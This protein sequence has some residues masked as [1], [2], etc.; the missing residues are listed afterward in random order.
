MNST[1]FAIIDENRTTEYA[2]HLETGYSEINAGQLT[3]NTLNIGAYDVNGTS[4]T[5]FIELKSNNIPT[6]TFPQLAGSGT[7]M[8][9]V[10]STGEVGA[11]T[12]PSGG[13]ISLTTTGSSGAAT[14]VG[15]TL[16]VPN[17][18]LSGL[19][20]V[21]SNSS[22]TGATK[23]K[24]TYDAK[25]LVTAGADAT[26]ADIADSTDKRYVTDA[27]LT[28]IGTI[29]SKLSGYL[30][31]LA[32]PSSTVTGTTSETQV[33][34]LLIP[35]NTFSANDI[36]NFT[37]T[38]AKTGT[39]AGF[40][41]RVKFS[42]SS[43]M[44]SG[45]TGQFAVCSPINTSLYLNMERKLMSISSGNLYTILNNTSLATDNS[46]NLNAI[47]SQAFDV[48]VNQYLYISITNNSATDSTILRGFK[49]SNL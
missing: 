28:S 48:T 44:P 3:N 9:T 5:N 25:G 19:G 33:L 45:T 35:A 16:N 2:L 11:T 31:K 17:Y 49:L 36:L 14:L 30:Y 41:V 42:T 6:M 26:T 7:R 12:I 43:T 15:S 40:G 21:A 34:Q 37:A 23:T 47:S 18:T 10:T 46:T 13:S 22:I 38:F 1:G 32:T 4:M 8:V 39:A 29:S 27:Q 20:G 24:I